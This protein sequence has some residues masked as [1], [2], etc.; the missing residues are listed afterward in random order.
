MKDIQLSQEEIKLSL[1]MDDKMVYVE[2]TEESITKKLLKLINNY[3]ND[4]RYKINI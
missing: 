2:K 1:F 3:S 4:V